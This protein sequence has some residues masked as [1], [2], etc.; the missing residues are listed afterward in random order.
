LKIVILGLDPRTHAATGKLA[1][2]R[3]D[4]NGVA[5]D[6]AE[7][8]PAGSFSGFARCLFEKGRWL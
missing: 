8:K 2:R 5:D 3:Q 6:T 4:G 1:F 7:P